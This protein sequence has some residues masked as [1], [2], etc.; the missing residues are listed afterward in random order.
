MKFRLL[1]AAMLLLYSQQAFAQMRSVSG[2][3]KDKNSGDALSGVAVMVESTTKG[4]FSDMSGKYT[5]EVPDDKAVLVFNLV[6][7]AEQKIEVGTKSTIDVML[8]ASDQMDEVV[9]TALGVP[10]SK[11][12]IGY[13]AQRI[14]GKEI[15]TARETNIVNAMQ[16]KV[17]GVQITGSTNLGGSSR[18]LIRG[19]KS[20]T[21]ENQ[22]LFIVDGVPIN[23]DNFS[24]RNQARGALGYDY[25]NA[26]QDINPADIADVQVLRGTAAALYGARGANGVILITTKKG[27]AATG[28]GRIPIGVS[29]TE[30][31][32]FDRVFVLPDYQNLYGGGPSPEFDSSITFPGLLMPR[33]NYDGSWG[34]K[35]EGQQVL[36]WNAFDNKYHPELYGRT[37]AWEAQPD[38]IKDFFV[39]GQSANTNIALEGANINSNF[40]LSLS[41]LNQKG[42]I[43][44]S[45]LK[46]N[47][48]SFNGG[49]LFNTKLST[50]I[51]AN[52][53][54]TV[55]KGRP[56][57]GYS[58]LASNFT[59]WWQRQINMS[60]LEDYKNP[61]GTQRSWNRFDE[62]DPN[63]LY[64]DNPYWTQYES[65][66]TD[67][68]D[69]IFG[70]ASLSY[71]LMKNLT[72]VG[73]A[74]TD[75]Y[76]DARQERVAVGSVSSIVKYSEDRI[77]FSENNYELKA[78]HTAS[79]NKVHDFSTLI[80]LNRRDAKTDRIYQESQGGLNIPNFYSLENSVDPILIDPNK[81]RKVVNS[82]FAALSYGYKNFLYVEV[83]GRN[84]WSST[85]P[86]GN[87]SYFYP[88]AS[89]SLIFSNLIDFKQM[90]YGKVRVSWS[91]VGN[92][93]DPYRLQTR[94]SPGQSYEGQGLY[95]LPSTINNPDLRPE[96]VRTFEVGTEMNFFLDRVHFDFTYYNALTT[97]NIFRIQQSA[98]SGSSF[99]FTNAGSME[100]K[101]I[102][103]STEFIPVKMKDG[104]EVGIGINYAR[105]RNEVIEL[106]KD[107]SGNEVNSLRLENAPFAT[108]IEARPGSAY[109][110]IV[111][112]DYAKDANGN[113]IIDPA[114]G[115]YERTPTVVPLG[116]VLADFTGGVSV[117][118]AYK[119]LKLYALVDFQ[120]GGNLFSMTNM[121]GKY[122]G[123][124]EETAEGGIRE[125]GIDVSGVALTGYDEEGNALSDG[126]PVTVNVPA[127][128]HFFVNQGYIIGAADVYDASFIKLREM[129]LTYDFAPKMLEKT[130]IQGLSVGITGRNLAILFKNVPH[131]D[132]EAAVSTSNVQGIEG[133]QLPTSRNISFILSAR[134]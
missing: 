133:G 102:E 132:P 27:K 31:F 101:G 112:Y 34:P 45:Q 82:A 125:N 38:N 81:A 127:V 94:P 49:H 88:S 36:P 106:Y 8:E 120:K 65:Y 87:N 64:W 74:M 75:F 25:G 19:A 90:S 62:F 122:S 13:A 105:N 52:Y 29:V 9:I 67:Q 10:R 95:Y 129:R 77:N 53:V 15:S 110:Q 111:G 72:L 22:P 3:I 44:N 108:F 26:A 1:I 71:K 6:G 98:A 59:Q 91:Q 40:R 60:E 93:T 57:T 128:D 56:A 5:I 119:G 33:Y 39:T 109:G 28:T 68:R 115:F 97:D 100:N 66:E 80:G 107:E 58:N 18:M 24:T 104:L 51:S 134:F 20:L 2:T 89:S 69:R 78:L 83:T 113:K 16:G 116:S 55:G 47:T 35:F 4:V 23:N 123:T 54:R 43:V 41:N 21:G 14:D 96:K 42:T 73:T 17:A 12:A 86:E 79:I 85:L 48:V 121:W 99:R 84:D 124:L 32:G 7:Y 76:S 131:I 114:S 92:D 118:A 30:N 46:R 103:I 63:P 37:V 130:P 70:N 117:W 11:K 61:D 50:N 126:T